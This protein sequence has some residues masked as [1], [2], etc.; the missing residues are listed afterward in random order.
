MLALAAKAM[1]AIFRPIASTHRHLPDFLFFQNQTGCCSNYPMKSKW[2]YGF[3]TGIG[4]LFI[5]LPLAMQ[6]SAQDETPGRLQL[7]RGVMCETI[8]AYE[9]NGIAVVFSI[10]V[11]RISCYTLFDNIARDSAV[12]H[13]WFRR[14]ELVTSKRLTIK[15]PKWGTYSSIQ[16]R[17]ADK[18]PWRVEVWQ[19]D[20]PLL[21]T[22]R[23][24]VTD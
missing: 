24:S 19:V 12:D 21:K 18:G 5:V 20:G 9:P 8:E 3:L 17:Q 7:V 4:I 11:G 2:I 23:F 16:L 13:K 15:A 6:A 14:D 22:I 1:G 10:N